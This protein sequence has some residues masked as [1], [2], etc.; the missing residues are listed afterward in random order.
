MA[1]SPD[2]ASN[3]LPV[4]AVERAQ[5]S[6]SRRT[7]GFLV[8][9]CVPSQPYGLIG[10][11]VGLTV[12]KIV[13]L[14]PNV[15]VAP[16]LAETDFIEIAAKGFRSVVNNRPDGEAP[17]QMRNLRAEI[18]AT[19]LGLK[20]CHQPVAMADVTDGAAVTGFARLMDDLPGPILFYCGSGTRCTIL[21]AQASVRRLG[22]SLTLE[23]AAQAGYNLE[24]VRDE[25]EKRFGEA[26]PNADARS[27]QLAGTL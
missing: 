3:G 18:A 27:P 23:I 4:H 10:A 8:V 20:F 21:W 19:G 9:F 12:V 16:Q 14:E 6:G 7:F 17:G 15:F 11:V 25:L 13:Q 1:P 2:P 24:V 22:I 5:Y 26:R